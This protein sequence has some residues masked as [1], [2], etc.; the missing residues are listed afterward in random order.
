[1]NN[2]WYLCAIMALGR[3]KSLATAHVF[4]YTTTM[5]TI[6]KAYRYRIIPT[7]EQQQ[8]LALQ[9]GHA[10][11][12]Y[13]HYRALREQIYQ[14]TGKG[15]SYADCTNDLPQLKRTYP[16]LKDADSQVLQQTLK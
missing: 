3:Y 11:F 1:M 7:G 16:W 15:L 9:F 2:W 13:N 14:A 4:W 10:R 6:Q 12:V 5:R 8:L